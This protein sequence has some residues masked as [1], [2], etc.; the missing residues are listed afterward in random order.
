MCGRR[1]GRDARPVQNGRGGGDGLTQAVEMAVIPLLLAFLGL[2]ADNRLGTV[3]L[4]TIALL[5][6]GTA[7]G[8]TRAYYAYRYQCDLEEEKRPWRSSGR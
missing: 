7:G 4:F 3:P 1:K 6:L 8:F 2:A 5:V